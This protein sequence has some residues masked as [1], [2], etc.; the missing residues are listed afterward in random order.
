MMRSMGR[1]PL[2]LFGVAAALTLAVA[3]SDDDE[4]DGD[5]SGGNAGESGSG[6]SSTGGRAGSSTGGR[7]GSSTGG[8]NTG[9]S[10]TGGSN[11][12]GRAGS[13]TGGSGGSTAGSSTGGSAGDE[14]GM[15]G[16]GGAEGGMGGDTGEGG[17]MIV[18]DVLDN[19]GFADYG[20]GGKTNAIPG[21]QESGDLEATY[22]E[23]DG[24]KLGAG[25]HMLAHWRGWSTELPEFT[26]STFQ[27][28][29]PI[30]NGTYTFSV[31]VKRKTMLTTQYLFARG[32]N[33]ADAT[34]E[35]K[36]DVP[37]PAT[38]TDYYQA[39]LGDIVVTSNQVTV[40]IYTHSWGND[41][42]NID[43]ATLTKNP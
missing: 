28:V 11:T 5:G 42:A 41:W 6:G 38:E 14:G 31:W 20:T 33:A 36:L 23:W 21:W 24:G 16:M 1:S 9:G 13:A 30:P 35:M 29:T 7:A 26:A 4:D 40:G 18:A 2:V 37:T 25:D 10:N 27:T 17:E 34:E 43:D 22:L 8:S 3:C 15:G 19:A 39:T 32:H 12:G